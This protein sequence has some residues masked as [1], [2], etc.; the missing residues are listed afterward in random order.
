MIENNKDKENLIDLI[1]KEKIY[2]LKSLG[3]EDKDIL[4]FY[5]DMERIPLQTEKLMEFLKNTFK[6]YKVVILNSD[7]INTEIIS[8]NK[9]TFIKELENMINILKEEEQIDRKQQQD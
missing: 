9:T 8:T 6:N 5:I 2:K 1:L 7:V 4:I 3:G